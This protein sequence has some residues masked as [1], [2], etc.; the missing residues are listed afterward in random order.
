[1]NHAKIQVL[2]V[3]DNPVDA[4]LVQQLLK[5]L[6]AELPVETRWVDDA[7]KALQEVQNRP[8]D[9]LL[10]D[11]Q[12]P[13]A[14]GLDVLSELRKFAQSQ[15]PAVIMLTATGSEK[16]AVEAMK[17]GARDYLRKDELAAAPLTRALMSALS[18]KRMQDQLD[19]YLA[20]TQAEL[21]MAR[22]LQHAMLPRRFP[23]FPHTAGEGDTALRFHA[24]YVST[25]D[26]GGDFYDV[27]PLSDT[28][29]GV[30]I[31]DVMGH[32]V[33][34]ALV[35]AMM[36]ALV[37]EL[38]PVARD[39]SQFLQGINHG[40]YAI[41]KDAAEPLFATAFYLV[42]DV[43]R[44][45][46]RFANAG[47]PLPFHLRRADR[48]VEQLRFAANGSGPALGLFDNPPFTTAVSDCAPGDLIIL[49]TDGLF[50]VLG[51]NNDEF[52]EERL[53]ATVQQR[54][55]LP[56]SELFDELIRVTR[57]HSAE[58]E[59]AD[60]VCLLGVEVTR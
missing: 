8:Y 13:D 42:A 38:L 23:T 3:D 10:L 22:Q 41:L 47:H 30:F 2:L 17:S 36:R 37:E 31:C 48:T 9:L 19:R 33:R 58:G 1:M 52:G 50:E 43:A 57:Q 12:L 7:A 16:I 60:D 35:T 32:G 28:E 4:A 54:Q 34:A 40:L 27:L 21:R 45:Q 55:Q 44:G 11:Y 49:V 20:Q 53:L 14:T 6:A 25:T 24:R 59:F 56:P 29:A 39:P 18:Q 5:N 26:L 46:I 51:P 15:Q